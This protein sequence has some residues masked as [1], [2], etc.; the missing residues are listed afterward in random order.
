MG[1]KEKHLTG[2]SSFA[3]I[4]YVKGKTLAPKFEAG[5]SRDGAVL[6]FVY[7]V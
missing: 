5:D 2:Y 7:F 1:A 6:I 4:A 3:I